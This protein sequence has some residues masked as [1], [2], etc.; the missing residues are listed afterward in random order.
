MKGIVLYIG[1]SSRTRRCQAVNVSLPPQ[2][3][4]PPGNH[5]VDGD[6]GG[7]HPR[8]PSPQCLSHLTC[9]HPFSKVRIS[10][11]KDLLPLHSQS[12]A[13]Q[14]RKV[15]L[16][17][18]QTHERKPPLQKHPSW[19]NAPSR[20]FSTPPLLPLG[21][22]TLDQRDGKARL[23]RG[24]AP[25]R[26]PPPAGP[27][28][29]GAPWR[30]GDGGRGTGACRGCLQEGPAG[31]RGAARGGCTSGV[32]GGDGWVP[33]GLPQLPLVVQLALQGARALLCG[34]CLLL[35]APDLPPHRLQG[36]TPR[37]RAGPVGGRAG[38]NG[39]GRLLP[40]GPGCRGCPGCPAPVR[41]A[42]A[43]LCY[44]GAPCGQE[45]SG[46]RGLQGGADEPQ[47]GARAPGAGT[48][49]RGARRGSRDRPGYCACSRRRVERRARSAAGVPGGLGA[50]GGHCTR[51]LASTSKAPPRRRGD[52]GKRS[53]LLRAIATPAGRGSA[54][55]PSPD[56]HAQEPEK[57]SC[58]S[59][60][61]I[62]PKGTDPNHKIIIP[63]RLILTTRLQPQHYPHS[64][65][66]HEVKTTHV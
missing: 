15:D 4:R 57:L 66:L 37:H 63:N 22:F 2:R 17:G 49:G 62:C 52:P 65:K 27:G 30:R 50:P 47:A 64:P 12:K 16:P 9:R 26:S 25:P 20:T 35:Q 40:C 43:S 34:V 38:C 19:E 60:A 48:A 54:P 53:W 29:P 21:A 33:Y 10:K 6:G 31:R 59:G 5:R 42:Q 1:S 51:V 32:C 11:R 24:R 39:R 14:Q 13:S 44:G 55:L 18:T 3:H 7:Q 46:S 41:P 28:A 23:R 8:A 61:G 56:S 45:Q 36:A 58:E